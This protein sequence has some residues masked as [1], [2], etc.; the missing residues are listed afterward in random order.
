MKKLIII[1][2]L[3]F[4]I[5][6]IEAQI[7]KVTTFDTI[8]LENM[9]DEY[10]NATIGVFDITKGG[11]LV[12]LKSFKNG[13]KHGLFLSAVNTLNPKQ[14]VYAELNY[15]NGILHGYSSGIERSGFY[16]NGK[17]HNLWE[18]TTD[19]GVYERTYYKKGRK[20][21]K[22]IYSLGNLEIE[23][24]YKNNL[25]HGI[26]LTRKD[27]KLIKKEVYKKGKLLK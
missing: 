24:N 6:K 4:S 9:P 2:L 18:H 14:I 5:I 22:Y 25:K 7:V 16:K 27:D 1:L 19:T 8:V 13:K 15:K 26:W 11:A 21:G 23:G 17:K 12:A 10:K 3:S 20:H